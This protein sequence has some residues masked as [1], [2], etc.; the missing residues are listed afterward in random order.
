MTLHRVVVQIGTIEPSTRASA[1]SFRQSDVPMTMSSASVGGEGAKAKRAHP[2]GNAQHAEEVVR[3]LGRDDLCLEF[4]RR[5]AR[6]S[7]WH[8]GRP[9]HPRTR[10]SV[11]AIGRELRKRRRAKRL[12]RR[13]GRGGT[14]ATPGS[15]TP[16]GRNSSALY[17]DRPMTVAAM[18]RLSEASAAPASR[19]C[20]PN[21]RSEY[22]RLDCSH[23]ASQKA[24][25][26]SPDQAETPAA[27]SRPLR[28][29]RFA[30]V[31]FGVPFGAPLRARVFRHEPAGDC[32][33]PSMQPAW[34]PPGRRGLADSRRARDPRAG[35]GPRLRR[36]RPRR[37]SR[38]RSISAPAA[39]PVARRRIGSQS[40]RDQVRGFHAPEGGVDRAARQARRVHDVESVDVAVGDGLENRGSGE[41]EIALWHDAEQFTT[42]DDY[43]IGHGT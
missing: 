27:R 35:T 42:C 14:G 17:A 33:Q 11:L 7:K 5:S 41:R 24:P 20:R 18:A 4:R 29:G 6:S 22:Q 13:C 37:F 26:L 3:D 21:R 34:L 16:G 2:C 9:R 32:H 1:P 10:G 38:A 8:R 39:A 15:P 36:A 23:S 30:M 43:Y 28:V 19:Q 31:E 25:E 40:R 12:V